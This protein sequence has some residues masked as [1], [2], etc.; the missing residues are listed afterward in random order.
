MTFVRR[1]LAVVI[2]LVVAPVAVGAAAPIIAIDPGHGG[3]DG[4]AVGILPPGTVTGLPVRVNST[5]GETNILEKDVNLDVARRVDIYLKAHGYAT[6]MTRTQDLAGGDTPF[7][8]VLADLQ[9]RVDVAE[10]AN[11]TL[12]VSLHENAL[13]ATATGTET[14][15]Y[16]YASQ[17]SKVLAQLI[18]SNLIAALG[19]PDRGVQ[20]AGFYVLRKTSMPA[21]LIEGMFLTNPSEALMLADPLTRQKIADAVGAGVVTYFEQGYGATT[22][23]PPV[24]VDTTP[25]YQVTAGSYRR[26]ASAKLRALHVRAMGFRAVIRSQYSKRLRR[27][28]FVV[29]SGKFAMLQNART[30]RDQ[31]RTRHLGA[32]IGPVP[33]RSRL[34]WGA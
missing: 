18:H 8:T 33:T 16:Y 20:S 7:T 31:L 25:K 19:L 34:V 13:S 9:A 28:V 27:S 23:P 4:G 32:V 21:V 3:A 1:I 22:D 2:A 10:T 11:A 5:T 24:K 30:L 6:V 14:Y 17:N 12:F 26:L 15:H 29:I